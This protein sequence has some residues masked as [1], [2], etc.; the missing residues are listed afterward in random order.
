MAYA[1][2]LQRNGGATSGPSFNDI[3]SHTA[4][5]IAQL[6]TYRNQDGSFKAG[7]D[8]DIIQID[9]IQHASSAFLSYHRNYDGLAA[10]GMQAAE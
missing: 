9:Y 7:A 1:D 5:D 2:M 4:T 3:M 6:L 10:R 8:S